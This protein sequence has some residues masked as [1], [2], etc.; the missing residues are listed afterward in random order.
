MQLTTEARIYARQVIREINRR[1][2]IGAAAFNATTW[3]TGTLG[4]F[5]RMNRSPGAFTDHAIDRTIDRLHA[6]PLYDRG[7]ATAFDITRFELMVLRTG[8]HTLTAIEDLEDGI[9]VQLH[10]Y[11]GKHLFSGYVISNIS[12]HALGRF[13]ERSTRK[14]TVQEGIQLAFVCGHAGRHAST[15]M[16]LQHS[17]INISY[18]AELIVTGSMKVSSYANNKFATAF[19]DCRTVLPRSACGGE[20]LIQASA[21]SACLMERGEI[22]DVPCIE[23]RPD[24]VLD[25]LAASKRPKH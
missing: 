23:R 10:A 13:Y 17:E 19:Y 7:F 8:G 2:P 9:I 11:K 24:F 5:D 25:T 18:A 21:M 16:H 15:Q 14:P 1:E 6:I 22:T 4:L 20:Q 3:E 12:T